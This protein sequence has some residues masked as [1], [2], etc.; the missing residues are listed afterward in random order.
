MIAAFFMALG[1]GNVLNIGQAIAVSVVPP[2]KV[3]VATS[4]YFIFSDVGMGMGAFVM[5]G[6]A[7]VKGFPFM[8]FIEGAMVIAALCLYWFLYGRKAR[9]GK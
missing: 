2:E 3:G 5:G 8:Y 6:I 1:Y 4:S 9:A 7:S